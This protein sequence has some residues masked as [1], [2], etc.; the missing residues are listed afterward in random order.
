[1]SK[2]NKET[3]T[4]K[5]GSFEMKR[6]GIL[7]IS[8]LLAAQITALHKEC[9]KTE[10]SGVLLFRTVSEDLER[11]ENF[12]AV[13]EAVYP[14]DFGTGA[15]TEYDHGEDSLEIFERYPK[16]DP[17]ANRTPWKL[18]HIH[19]H[20][21]MGA[22][23][24]GTDDGEL[25]ENANKYP[26][27]LSLVVDFKGTYKAKVA[28]IAETQRK[29]SYKF[30]NK[31]RVVD[32]PSESMLV[33]F[34][35]DV[36]MM[37][38]EWFYQR[39][40]ELDVR[41][42]K[43]TYSSTP[44]IPYTSPTTT[45]PARTGSNHNPTPTNSTVGESYGSTRSLGRIAWFER[46]RKRLPSLF[47]DEKSAKDTAFYWI[48]DVAAKENDLSTPAKIDTYLEAIEIEIPYWLDR[49][50]QQEIKGNIYA[51]EQIMRAAVDLFEVYKPTD[52]LSTKVVAMLKRFVEKN[53]DT[54]YASSKAD[55]KDD[56]DD[57]DKKSTIPGTHMVP[58]PPY[59]EGDVLD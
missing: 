47:L 44:T 40:D 42:K 6:H 51:E 55:G 39:L 4:V 14:M 13:A 3:S 53:Y 21:D 10:W 50:F 34:N 45:H 31:R 56:D 36:K 12:R 9:G 22:F 41:G 38:D 32:V 52:V 43:T 7:Q 30:R 16:A 33:T 57:D 54:T 49:E 27:Y 15:Y 24:S 35:L 17:E 28:F 46:L 59:G 29:I 23:F 11:P 48:F 5:G 26:Y 19:T 37:L 2:H 8:P 20:H 1:M 25:R 58:S 18:G